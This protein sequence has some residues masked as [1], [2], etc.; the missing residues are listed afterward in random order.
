MYAIR[1]G[2]TAMEY[3]NT[4]QTAKI[5]GVSKQFLEVARCK[6][7]GPPFLKLG[8]RVVYR[9]TDVDE[10]AAAQLRKPMKR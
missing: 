3:R 7:E 9:I 1:E 10:W 6:G 5:L 2:K 8:K 4:E